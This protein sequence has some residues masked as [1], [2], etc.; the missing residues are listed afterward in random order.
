[1]TAAGPGR[2]TGA[3]EGAPAEDTPAAYLGQTEY[4]E[5]AEGAE[6]AGDAGGDWAA[7]KR[8]GMLLAGAM[9]GLLLDRLVPGGWLAGALVGGLFVVLTGAALRASARG[10]PSL[11]CVPAGPVLVVGPALV[12][13]AVPLPAWAAVV[14]GVYSAVMVVCW[15]P[16][17]A[18]DHGAAL[19]HDPRDIARAAVEHQRRRRVAMRGE[20][21]LARV[22]EALAPAFPPVW[23]RRR[24]ANNRW[25][26]RRYYRH[27][28]RRVRRGS[29]R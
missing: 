14:M 26:R 22:T 2:D 12:V 11:G 29:V 15:V 16:V 27:R 9:G 4:A 19:R 18:A 13:W 8:F 10:G 25:A 24:L 3:D 1:M 5:G 28:G 23:L 21:W 6:G 20:S 7:P 17:I